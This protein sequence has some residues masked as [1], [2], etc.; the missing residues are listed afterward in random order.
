MLSGVDGET[1]EGDLSLELGVRCL[2]KLQRQTWQARVSAVKAS[3]RDAERAGN[4]TEALRLYEE[5][6][7]FE[8]SQRAGDVQ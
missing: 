5:L 6:N 7:R 8:K 2:E 1:N 4:P 3:I